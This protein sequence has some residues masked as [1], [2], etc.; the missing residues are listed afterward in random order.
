MDLREKKTLKNIKNAFLK[1]RAQKPLERITVKE[2]AEQAEI[3]KA[4]FYLHYRDLYDLSAR[5]QEEV[6]E[7][8]L[9]S[10]S[11]PDIPLF[12]TSQIAQALFASFQVHEKWIDILFSGSQ[13]AV[14]PERIE[15]GVWDLAVRSE[16]AYK[17]DAELNVRLC[18]EI[19]G[20]YYAYEQNHKKFGEKKVIEL[21]DKISQENSAHMPQ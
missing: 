9:K 11:V 18:Y 2:L 8:I 16:P 21:I 13:S 6:I 3:S 7:S 1:L 17:N 20:S 4:T 10:V 5:L 15:K 14:L 12:K 19:Y